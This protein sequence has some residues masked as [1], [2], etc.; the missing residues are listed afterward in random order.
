MSYDLMLFNVA[1]P[2][3]RPDDLT[4][5][6]FLPLGESQA[7]VRAKIDRFQP[8]ITWGADGW[9]TVWKDGKD[10]GFSIYPVDPDLR[11]VSLKG[12][13]RREALAIAEPN[14]WRVFC[15][16]DSIFVTKENA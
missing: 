15:E 2:A 3:P 7:D 10:I 8:G 14:G 5:A 6:D 1:G 4:D 16:V 9:G 13:E 11:S 12:A